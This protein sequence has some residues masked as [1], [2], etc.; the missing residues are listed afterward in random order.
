MLLG[1][2]GERLEEGVR[3]EVDDALQFLVNVQRLRRL[4]LRG[5]QCREPSEQFLLELLAPAAG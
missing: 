1:N 4:P 3:V 5:G 2:V